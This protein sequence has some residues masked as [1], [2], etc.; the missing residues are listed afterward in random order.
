MFIRSYEGGQDLYIEFKNRVSGLT[1]D[2]PETIF[3]P[4]AEGGKSVGLPLCYRLLKDMGG[5]LS[6]DYSEDF[7]VFTV[8]LPKAVPSTHE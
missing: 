1:H 3:M 5:L 6:Y 7:M 8:S 4:F 2:D